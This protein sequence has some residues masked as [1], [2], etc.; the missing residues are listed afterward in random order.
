[1]IIDA[2]DMVLLA[3]G[4]MG[5]GLASLYITRRFIHRPTL[6]FSLR[7]AAVLHKND[8]GRSFQMFSKGQEL[9]NLC[10][11]NLEIKLNGHSDISKD[12]VPEDNKPMMFFPSFTTYDVRT[13]EWDET[14]FE[15]PLGIAANGSMVIININRIRANT[16]A[17]FQII[18]SFWPNAPTPADYL[19]SFYPGAMHNVDVSAIGN[20]KRPWLRTRDERIDF[21][22]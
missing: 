17:R 20:I 13:I 8:F 18:G 2:K 16:T 12:Q 3:G 9:N 7:K 4:I 22:H 15:I 19:V 14:R 11:F 10:V 21:L 5:G 1:M 6:Q